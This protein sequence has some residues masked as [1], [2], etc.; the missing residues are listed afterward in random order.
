MRQKEEEDKAKSNI[1]PD[2]FGTGLERVNSGFQA[3]ANM[4]K[5]H[6]GDTDSDEENLRFLN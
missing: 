2:G 5:D 6:A 1:L 4:Q 3:I